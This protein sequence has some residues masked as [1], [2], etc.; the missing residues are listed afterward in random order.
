MRTM[1]KSILALAREALWVGQAALPPYS[2]SHSRHDYTQAQLFALLVL[3]QALRLDYRGLVALVAEWSE[4]RHILGLSKVPHHSTLCYAEHRL[5]AEAEKGGPSSRLSVP[6]SAGPLAWGCSTA[7]RSRRSTPPAWRPDM[8]AS[9]TA[10]APRGSLAVLVQACIG[11]ARRS[12]RTGV[13][14]T[15][16]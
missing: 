3:R 11:S 12:R 10:T 7:K 16:S 2:C 6:S 9:I 4:L 8:P 13:P 1:T 14:A 15:R 5:L